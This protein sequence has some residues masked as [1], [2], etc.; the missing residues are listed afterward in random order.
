MINML[1]NGYFLK[2]GKSK[3][4]VVGADFLKWLKGSLIK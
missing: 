2:R 1:R 4:V 3:V